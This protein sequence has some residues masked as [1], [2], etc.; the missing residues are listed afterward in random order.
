MWVFP[1]SLLLCKQDDYTV[2]GVL[3]DSGHK[4][5]QGYLNFQ[6]IIRFLE[7]TGKCNFLYAHKKGMSFPASNVTEVTNALQHFT[8]ICNTEFHPSQKINGGSIGRRSLMP[9]SKV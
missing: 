7:Y 5:H 1:R 6:K 3:R 4:L 8:Q 9:L 2:P